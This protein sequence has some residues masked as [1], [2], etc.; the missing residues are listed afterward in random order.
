MNPENGPYIWCSVVG[1]KIIPLGHGKSINKAKN[2]RPSKNE[3][4]GIL[5]LFKLV[6][7]DSELI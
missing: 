4:V 5:K 6:E 3:G 7:L 2:D 1:E